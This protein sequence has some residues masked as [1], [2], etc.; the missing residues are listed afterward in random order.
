MGARVCVRAICTNLGLGPA[1]QEVLSLNLLDRGNYVL[2]LDSFVRRLFHTREVFHFW[3]V[4]C[5][6]GDIGD[7]SSETYRDFLASCAVRFPTVLLLAGNNEYRN[8]DGS[9]RTMAQTE[10]LIRQAAAAHLNVHF[11][12]N[13]TYV[14]GNIAFIGTT[15]W[16]YLPDTPLP[17][18]PSSEG[19]E[20]AADNGTTDHHRL[21]GG[22]DGAAAAAAADTPA[23]KMMVP[24]ITPLDVLPP[25]HAV[26]PVIPA[27]SFTQ[28]TDAAWDI[29]PIAAAASTTSVRADVKAQGAVCK[30]GDEAASMWRHRLVTGSEQPQGRQASSHKPPPATIREFIGETSLDYR[31]IFASPG[32]PPITPEVTN[33]L[34]VSSLEYLRGAVKAASERGLLPVVLSHH[35]PS[36]RGTSRPAFAGHPSTHAYSTD[37]DAYLA[38]SG[39]AAWYCGHTHYNFDL[40]LPGGVRLASN[41]FGSQPKPADGYSRNWQHRLPTASRDGR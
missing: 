22:N 7:P 33:S 29:G 6:L 12:Q 10:E 28:D 24:G 4:L 19:E 18:P 36:M 17:P 15:L 38:D 5:L 14:L 27:V 11:L 8:H 39:I 20:K 1:S 31:R 2:T 21:A 40:L 30:G 34:F 25:L 23:A 32:G 35:A 37:L 9:S 13:D 3:K 26:L 41:Q 16:S